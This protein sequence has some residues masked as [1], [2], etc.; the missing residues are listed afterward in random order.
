MKF[1][2]VADNC[3][4]A[5]ETI[6]RVFSSNAKLIIDAAIDRYTIFYENKE[7]AKTALSRLFLAGKKIDL[8]FNLK[9]VKTEIK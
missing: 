6:Q 1:V 4:I 5:E 2:K 7:D 8:L 3:W 9:H